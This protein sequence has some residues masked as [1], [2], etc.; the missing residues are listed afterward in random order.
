MGLKQDADQ[1]DKRTNEIGTS[2][3]LLDTMPTISG[4]IFTADALLTQRALATYL[5]DRGADYVFTVKGNQKTLLAD[6]RTLF[7]DIIHAWDP[8]FVTE[9]PKPEHGRHET[10]SIWVSDQLNDY[11]R[12]PGVPQVF[13]IKRDVHEIASG[14]RSCTIAYGVTSLS[15]TA[16]SA[17]R[18]LELN[19][20]YWCIEAMHHILDWSFDEDRG[21]IRSG[22]GPEITT[23]FRRFAIGL[24]KTRGLPVAE[25]TCALNRKTRRV[26]DFLKLTGN[27]RPRKCTEN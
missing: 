1:E 11:A 25:T 24:I 9:T 27:S 21:R 20:T 23:Q 12:F 19:R 13:A 5:N 10:C 2:I 3:P 17:A 14:R 26:L 6:I 7:T 15:G 8:D 22:H 4:K 16:A 18:L